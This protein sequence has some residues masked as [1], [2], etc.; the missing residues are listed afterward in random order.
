MLLV[1][2]GLFFVSQCVIANAYAVTVAW[3]TSDPS[4]PE[5]HMQV[6]IR[7]SG[8]A[9]VAYFEPTLWYIADVP[10][11]HAL[12]DTKEKKTLVHKN[13]ADYQR[14]EF[15]DHFTITE[16]GQI[17]SEPLYY[18]GKAVLNPRHDAVILQSGDTIDVH[19]NILRTV[20]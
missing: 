16:T 14:V 12:L 5:I 19:W 15:V 1:V 11:V 10:G 6:I 17:T 4:L 7:D 3:P 13:N 20:Q 8:G 2:L 9:L 18:K